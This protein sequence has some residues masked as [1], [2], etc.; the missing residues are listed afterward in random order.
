M[1]KSLYLPLLALLTASC[2]Q[3]KDPAAEAWATLYPQ[4]EQSIVAPTFP[5]RDFPI[6]DF[7]AVAD[8]STVLNHAAINNAILACSEAGGGRVVVPA[9]TWHTGPITIKSNVNLHIQ[10]N[11]RLLFTADTTQYPFVLTRWEGVDCYNFQPMIY[12]YGET[13]VALTGKGTVDGGADRTN[14][15]PMSAKGWGYEPGMVSQRT[16]RPKLLQWAE[17]NVPVEER[18]LTPNDGM[19]PQLVN[20][21]KCE[22]VL[23]ED[24]TL[25]RSPFWVVHPLMCKNLTVRG[26]HI[27]NDGPNGDGCDP[28]S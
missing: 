15:W 14:W 10:E 12:A 27:Q 19:R 6:T 8:D 16:G 25:L 23:I 20:F 28:E 4:I 17:D 7:G 18:R 5:D 2:A 1:K 3:Q 11:A 13:N 22:N 24:L 26:L 9:G 21:Y